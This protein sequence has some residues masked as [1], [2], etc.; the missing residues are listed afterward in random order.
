MCVGPYPPG[1][2]EAREARQRR[3]SRQ[4]TTRTQRMITSEQRDEYHALLQRLVTDT[5]DEDDP[6]G[7]FTE[8]SPLPKAA[9]TLPSPKAAP[10]QSSAA[11]DVPTDVD[12]EDTEDDGST[13]SRAALPRTAAAVKARAEGD[14][15]CVLFC[16]VCT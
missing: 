15:P 10:T 14:V 6:L 7:L 8:A 4:A 1:Y 13:G 11:G 9:P 3:D 12:S 2:I 16:R 5:E